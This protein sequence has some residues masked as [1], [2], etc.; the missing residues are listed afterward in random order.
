MAKLPKGITLRGSKYRVSIMVDGERKTGT[1]DT[2]EAAM[3]LAHNIRHGLEDK[4][5]SEN[6]T[7]LQ[8][9]KS[10]VEGHL[11]PGDYAE[12]TV[13]QYTSSSS[14]APRRPLMSSPRRTSS[15]TPQRC[16]VTVIWSPP[17]SMETS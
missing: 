2:L 6:W 13:L 7:P 10:Y 15:I 12:K 4:S 16:A 14:L 9:L 5:R 17:P 11:L 3:Q 8:A 1:A